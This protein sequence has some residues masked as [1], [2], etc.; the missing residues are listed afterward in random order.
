MTGNGNHDVDVAVIGGGPAGATVAAMLA[1]RG[2][3]V[4]MFDRDEFPRPKVCGCCLADRGVTVLRELGLQSLIDRGLTLAEVELGAGGRH[5]RLPF[6]GSIVVSREDL[7]TTLVEHA[8]TAGV[9]VQTRTRAAVDSDRIVR[10]RGLDDGEERA[11]RAR[12][13]VA[14]DGLD[15]RALDALPH[16]SW[17]VSGGSRFGA[18][19][20]IPASEVPSEAPPPGRLDMLAHRAGYLGVVRLPGGGLDLAAAFDN[21]AIRAL[22][23]PAAAAA[24]ILQAQNRP[25]L[26]AVASRL[27]WRGTPRL[28]RR[29]RVA[30][31]RIACVGDAAGYVEPFTGEGMSW[32]LG[33]ATSL[34][35][36]IDRA[37]LEN[38]TL[39]GWRRTH[40]GLVGRDRRRCRLVAQAVRMPGLAH[41]AIRV[42][43]V[44]PFIR[45]RLA[46]AASGGR[47]SSPGDLIGGRS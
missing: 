33:T 14:A 44:A 25:S 35:D 39:D 26:A 5:L 45:R 7:D 46:D 20:T 38:G 15:G 42:A 29:R 19:M 41:A 23:G 47:P 24:S 6:P 36:M 28:T 22:G 12:F 18:G 32:A 13:I 17:K 16:F 40:A 2:H 11:V 4:M 1:T 21:R 30:D 31:E 43:S 34:A 37:I 8:R 27:K 3:D 9:T 10:T